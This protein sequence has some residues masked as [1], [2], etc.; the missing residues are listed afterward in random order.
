MPTIIIKDG[1]AVYDD[2]RGETL[3]ARG[4]F[5]GIHRDPTTTTENAFTVTVPSLSRHFKGGQWQW[6]GEK[7]TPLPAYLP[8]ILKK[9]KSD[10]LAEINAAYESAI[11][12]LTAT[13]PASERESFY[14]QESEALAWT[15]DPESETP[16]VDALAT[17]RQMD[18]AELMQ[19]I[20]AKAVLFSPASGYLTGQRQRYED[21]LEDAE[22]LEEVA[23]I[24]PEYTMPEGV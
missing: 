8:D 14:K 19:R 20:I 13:Y 1:I 11:A 6:D 3:T 12:A 10:K 4:T 15:T 7:L 5:W 23:A 16:F 24:V 22:T 2:S 21:M 9:T 17:G 18:K